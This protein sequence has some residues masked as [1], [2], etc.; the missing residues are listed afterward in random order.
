MKSTI[1]HLLVN[2]IFLVIGGFSIWR[3]AQLIDF[4]QI[5]ETLTSLKTKIVLLVLVATVS[6]YLFR[7]ARWMLLLNSKTKQVDFLTTSSALLF[8]YF[9][10]LG[11]P[12]L[13]EFTRA[14]AIKK[15]T[16]LS[17]PYVL[18]TIIVERF[19]DVLSLLFLL[20]FYLI[21]YNDILFQFYTE[22]VL[23]NLIKLPTIP[24]W[25]LVTVLLG[26]GFTTY[27][28]FKK[29]PQI[30]KAQF[31]SLLSGFR[32]VLVMPNKFLFFGLT[33]G[34]WLSYFFTSYICFFTFNHSYELSITA[35]L[36]VLILGSVAR[37]IPIQ[38]GA[39]GVYHLAVVA[40]LTLSVF[41]VDEQTAFTIAFIIHAIQT[42]FQLVI[43]AIMALY[44]S[45]R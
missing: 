30:I 26:G 41:G 18:G 8:G 4:T 15:Q 27:F 19:V 31:K 14:G 35:G 34:R 25:L 38:G 21:T 40:V 44:V 43:G 2:L 39:M 7:I 28:I 17:F 16:K 42:L 22:K 11:V 29:L 5:V 37:S 3:M 10:N 23:F 1:K 12:R 6:A 32:S 33:I 20:F 13:G 24:L 9:I 36:S 45:F